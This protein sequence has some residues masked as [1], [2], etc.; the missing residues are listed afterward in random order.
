M[1]LIFLKKGYPPA[2]IKKEERRTYLASLSKA[3]GGDLHPFLT[4][5]ADSLI[6]TQQLIIEELMKKQNA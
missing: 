1:N 2:I 3:D 6:N 4:F 5:V